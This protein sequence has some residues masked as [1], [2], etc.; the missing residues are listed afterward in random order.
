MANTKAQKS[1]IQA[2][3]ESLTQ[4]NFDEAVRIFQESY[5]NQTVV[6]VNGPHDGGCDIKIFQGKREIKT[7]VQVTIQKKGWENKLK[8][9]LIK[10]D[11]LISQYG[12]SPKF[13]FFY[14]RA[15]S[16]SKIDECIQFAKQK[17]DIE[18]T[19]YEANRL[20]QL[21][22]PELKRYIRSLYDDIPL[23]QLG[24]DKSIQSLYDF[25]AVGSNPSDIKNGILNSLIIFIL[26]KNGSMKID[27]LKSE[28]EK[29]TDKVFPDIQHIINLLKSK[30]QIVNDPNINGNILLSEAEYENATD[31]YASAALIERDFIKSYEEIVFHYSIEDSKAVLE[32]LKELY[33]NFYKSD[34]NENDPTNINTNTTIFDEFSTFLKNH[35]LSENQ[36]N[37]FV[38]EIRQ[39]CKDNTYLNRIAASETFFSLYKSDRL[40]QYINQREKH[41]FLDTPALVYLL[42]ATF[43][44]DSTEDWNDPLYLSMKSLYVQQYQ[45]ERTIHFHIMQDY[46]GEVAGEL[47]KAYKIASFESYSFFKNLGS[48]TNTFYNFYQH[49]KDKNII[50]EDE[51]ISDFV[52]FIDCFGIDEDCLTSTNNRDFIKRLREIVEDCGIEII[53]CPWYDNFSEAKTEYEKKLLKYG[54]NKSSSAVNNDTKQI[55]YLLNTDSIENTILTTWDST[56]SDLR[57]TLM[58]K[59]EKYSFFPIYNPAKLS[60]KIALENFNINSSA[61]TN[62]IFMYADKTFGLFNKVRSLIEIIA[63]IIGG[64]K[65]RDIKVLKA[66]GEIRKQQIESM[67]YNEKDLYNKNLPIEDVVIKMIPDKTMQE[68]DSSILKRFE[69][70]FLNDDNVEY[71]TNQIKRGAEAMSNNKEI[72]L[73]DFFEKISKVELF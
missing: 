15:I 6:N 30:Q 17:Y 71:I 63:P 61:I 45:N 24:L 39:L 25:L 66:M 62:D 49:I 10:V 36:R 59:N 67:E 1:F 22:C 21:P 7:C 2:A 53:S 12:Y 43:E 35:I 4:E 47:Y 57:N 41:I 13:E 31:I 11:K 26:Y 5:F 58:R 52:D 68:L 28:L 73:T 51:Q 42:C 38:M 34:I 18:L 48:T 16:Q 46:I 19:I 32:K 37:D 23:E 54:K 72:D 27:A 69:A 50:V 9:D 29:R 3:L 60:N 8:N 64:K 40:E 33:H 65:N 55:L 70:F 44:L 14:S 20:A 56:L